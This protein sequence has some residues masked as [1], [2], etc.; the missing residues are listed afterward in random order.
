MG[1]DAIILAGGAAVRMG[2]RDKA[3]LEVGGRRLL[4]VALAAI[5]GAGRIVVVGP[6]REAPPEVLWTREEPP[7]GGPVAAVAAGLEEVRSPTVAVLAVDLPFVR[8]G[9]VAS[10][11]EATRGRAGGAIAVDADG[12]DQP[13]FAVYAADALRGELRRLEDPAGA[14]MRNLVRGLELVRV[15]L[16]P[17]ALDCDTWD[18]LAA[19]RRTTE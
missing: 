7:G 18:Q 15:D 1:F 13:L 14:S 17:A 11:L 12:R 16:G 5:E 8:P 6:H 9:S 4:D 2:G 10:L 19:A 3:E